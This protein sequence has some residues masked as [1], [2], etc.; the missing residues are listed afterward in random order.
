LIKSPDS[1]D[2]FYIKHLIHILY[3]Q[4]DFLIPARQKSNHPFYS[5]EA[6][7]KFGIL[8]AVMIIIG[9]ASVNGYCEEPNSRVLNAGLTIT[10]ESLQ[11]KIDLINERKGVD[12]NAKAKILKF[13]QSAQD[14]LNN[15]EGFKNQTASFKQAISEAPNAIK[16]SQ[17]EIERLQE[18]ISQSSLED[19][20]KIPDEELEQR[21]II[22]KGKLSTLD[23]QITKLEN[24]L[25][26][27]SARP[28]HIRQEVLQ[29]QQDLEAARQ[30]LDEAANASTSDSALEAD[31]RQ[32]YL[33]T[34]NDART[35][36]LKMLDMEGISNPLRVERLKIQ[37]QLLNLQKNLLTEAINAIEN[38]IAERH[39]Q[40]AKDIENALTQAES[41]LAGKT[42][43]IQ[44]IMRKN[45]QYSRDLQR[46]SERTEY[47]SQQK[48]ML[49]AKIGQ[50]ES[51]YK[52]AEKKI[53]LAGLSPALGRILHAQRRSLL[54][55]D[56]AL[57]QSDRIQSETATA[58]LEQFKIEDRLKELNDFDA[59]LKQQMA[60]YVDPALPVNQR[61]MTQAE[62]R[63]LLNKQKELLNNLSVAYSTYLRMLGDYEFISNQLIDLKQKFIAYLNEK[64]LWVKSSEPLT[65]DFFANLY[66]SAAW[67]LSPINW[68]LLLKDTLGLL[69]NSAFLALLG[70]LS[71]AILLYCKKKA[72]QRIRF[73]SEK[74]QKI[75]T[76]NINY[77]WAELV[78]T[79][80]LVAPLPL[81]L[82]FTG[83]FLVNH[84]NV[85]NF[86]R[87]IGEGLSG[88]A[89]PFFF[90][91]FFYRLFA[92]QGIARKHF[93]WQQETTDLLYRQLAWLRFVV[94][95]GIFIITSTGASKAA[96]YGDTLGRLVLI[97]ILLALITVFSRLLNPWRG[98]LKNYY[99][100]HPDHWLTALRHVW[101]A[102]AYIAP[103]IIIGFAA[104]GYYLSALELHQ[105]LILTIRLIFFL[106]IIY[107]LVIRWLTL[108]N[109]Q[110]AIRNAQEKRKAA[111]A[112]KPA[113]SAADDPALPVDERQIDIPKINEQTIQLLNVFT[114][115]SVLIGLWLIWKN[116][117]PAFSFLDNIVLWQHLV[118]ID[119][120]ESYR[121]I[122]LTNVVLASG[123][124]FI[125]I[126]AIRNFYSVMEL[127]VFRRLSIATGNRYA[128]NQLARYI[129]V[130]VGII[131]VFSELGGSWAQVQWLVAAL[132]VGLGFGLQEIFANL[133]SGIILLFER[134]IRIGD[135]VTIDNIT[136]K[137]SRIEMRATTLIDF[138]QKDLIVPNKTFITSQLV[139]WTLSDA[140]TRLVI[141]IGI[142]Y[143]TDVEK[144]LKVMVETVRSTPRVLAE[145]EPSVLFNGFG[146]SSL[147]FLIRIYVSE[148]SH[149]LP[150]THDLLLRLEKALREHQIEIPFPQREIYVRAM[151]TKT[152]K[153]E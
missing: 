81:L 74:I 32:Q 132:S 77:T 27:Q 111:L 52:S 123:Y 47:Y 112:E 25:V 137:V 133:V 125:V 13:Y 124:V 53:N 101:Y 147:D 139:N 143:N 5:P 110:L 30:K 26:V 36:E 55:P 144:A 14:N 11:T 92:A 18:Q 34:L 33:K 37:I 3:K 85:A 46:L 128:V 19:F 94:I 65:S 149:R 145:P 121:P 31:A 82:F 75:Y 42:P 76:D 79:L 63:V 113:I 148:L 130:A 62:A 43:L 70:A 90:V 129:L 89:I 8:F 95:I 45:I 108:V 39:Q 107:A 35:T 105:K 97:V 126:I 114:V 87:A 152:K 119:N 120:Q 131:S 96:V 28:Q 64:L 98:V 23:E 9:A 22:E 66:H 50:V 69:L 59:A 73:I 54:T 17:K 48:T 12:E 67:L 56:P 58:S 21:L 135:T 49:E 153:A 93:Q 146:E 100:Q 16:K 127:L 142:A 102:S 72:K 38:L 136:G 118:K 134:P 84:G 80:M 40:Q 20:S 104:T 122:T 71:F 4:A 140:T 106:V 1:N 78:Y 61:M 44:T 109:R 7:S 91:Q 51:D 24:D 60:A 138:D 88:A 83:K 116:I 57:T 150:V 68:A 15:I 6:M 117:L 2:K 41:E 115:F 29:A 99:Q 151:P 141:P 10:K 103:L 86:T